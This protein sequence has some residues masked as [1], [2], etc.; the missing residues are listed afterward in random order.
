M[1]TCKACGHECDGD[2][3]NC[4]GMVEGQ[5]NCPIC[6]R[7][8]PPPITPARCDDADCWCRDG[9]EHI[10]AGDNCVC[11]GGDEDKNP[12][13]DFEDHVDGGRYD[14][15]DD[16]EALASAGMGTDEDYFFGDTE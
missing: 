16:A 7:H 12:G 3:T 1:M 2:C 8:A 13:N 4:G 10:C 6:Q 9:D 15:S 5:D 11:I 14:L